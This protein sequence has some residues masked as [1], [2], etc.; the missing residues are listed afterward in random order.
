[1]KQVKVLHIG[2]SRKW[3]GGENQVRLLIEELQR[4][5]DGSQHFL[6]FP[7]DAIIFERLKHGVQGIV[8]LASTSPADPRAIW[9][10]RQACKKHDINVLHP[11]SSKAHSL[12]LLVK[13]TMPSLK[14]LVHRRVDNPIKTRAGTRKKYLT[15][16]V[17]AFLCVSSAIQTMLIEYG[18]PADKLRLVPDSIDTTPYDDLVKAYEK[19]A[20]CN[21][22]G[23]DA[24]LPMIGFIAALEDQKNPELFVES[25][26]ALAKSGVK[27]N[28]IMAG[29]GSKKDVII[30][31][32]KQ[33]SLQA[34][35]KMLGFVTA[36]EPV[37]A[38]LDVFVLPSRNE[39]LGTV[40]L[41]A[42][43]ARA[44][45]VASNV[46]GIGEAVIDRKT[47]LLVNEA[48]PASFSAAI[49]TV[50]SDV[51]LSQNLVENAVAHTQ[52]N[53]SLPLMAE[54]TSQCYSQILGVTD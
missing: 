38:A 50:L 48:A 14:L 41:E 40:M 23:F 3:R 32:I 42:M 21:K 34:Q 4:Q 47:G 1:M 17:D 44:V 7:K 8:S 9:A 46:G 16:Q 26:S 43:A 24:E 28:A 22:H 31:L 27:F 15:E 51:S 30:D 49:K 36:V 39:G 33:H 13:R 53:F 20:L 37:F 12:A 5:E 29:A 11:H 52:K 6:A 19:A 10:I 2:H 45:V 54:Q 35:V 18:V 25:L